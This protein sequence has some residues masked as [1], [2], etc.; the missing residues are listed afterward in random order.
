[1]LELLIIL[2]NYL[3]LKI[4]F[5]RFIFILIILSI[6][7]II[8]ESFFSHSAQRSMYG[9]SFRF[10]CWSYFSYYYL[11]VFAELSTVYLIMVR[12][13]LNAILFLFLNLYSTSSI[14]LP[15]TLCSYYYYYYSLPS[16]NLVYCVIFYQI[17]LVFFAE[18]S[19]VYLIMVRS[20]LI[21]SQ[22]TWYW[23]LPIIYDWH[24]LVFVGNIM[25]CLLFILLYL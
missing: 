13:S 24:I 16:M 4:H 5:F 20:S 8:F 14:I 9:F 7:S 19:T 6:K 21:L 3:Y 12:S 18:L 1:L 23:I 15:S 17:P 25:F 11:W 22:L 2:T 10:F